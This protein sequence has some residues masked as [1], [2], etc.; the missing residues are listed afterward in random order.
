[1]IKKVFFVFQN[2]PK[3][4]FSALQTKMIKILICCLFIHFHFFSRVRLFWGAT[5]MNGLLSNLDRKNNEKPFVLTR[6]KIDGSSQP[7]CPNLKDT[8]SVFDLCA[9]EGMSFLP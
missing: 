4:L 8:T 9:I 1:M 2:F 3:H 6:N 5:G 7:I